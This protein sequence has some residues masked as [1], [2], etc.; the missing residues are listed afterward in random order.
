MFWRNSDEQ[1]QKMYVQTILYFF[2][3]CCKIRVGESLKLRNQFLLPNQKKNKTHKH[4]LSKEK[5]IVPPF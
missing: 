5:K 4:I 3:N 2:P 1:R